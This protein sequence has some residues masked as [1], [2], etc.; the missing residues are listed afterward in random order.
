MM[1]VELQRVGTSKISIGFSTLTR[2]DCSTQ[3]NA[4][5]CY[6]LER[7]FLT[8]KRS[9]LEERQEIFLQ[10]H[11]YCNIHRCHPNLSR[12]PPRQDW[13]CAANIAFLMP[14]HFKFDNKAISRSTSSPRVFH[15]QAHSNKQKRYFE[16]QK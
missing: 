7:K 9:L 5:F 10:Y 1:Y 3:D 13:Q 15:F 11:L 4:F 12:M 6:A 16:G 2:Q 8:I 14:V